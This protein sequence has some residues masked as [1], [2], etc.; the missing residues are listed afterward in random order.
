[1][2]FHSYP[3]HTITS[4]IVNS[5]NPP[6]GFAGGIVVPITTT[7]LQAY[8]PPFYSENAGADK[9]F[10]RTMFTVKPNQIPSTQTNFPV[11]IETT[12]GI[13]EVLQ[14]LGQDIRVVI[15][16]TTLLNYEIE[17]WNST[18]RELVIWFDPLTTQQNTLVELYTGNATV[19]DAQNK[20]GVYKSSFKALYHMNDISVSG[21][22]DI[23]DS[24]SNIASG[25]SVTGNYSSVNGKIGKAIQKLA[26]AN[27]F[28]RLPFGSIL[29]GNLT[30]FTL[31]SLIN[32]TALNGY[33]SLIPFGNVGDEVLLAIHDAKIA[34]F[35]TWFSPTLTETTDTITTGTFAM[36]HVTVE[37][38]N[39]IKIYINGELKKSAT[40]SGQIILTNTNRR[41]F[42]DGGSEFYSGIFDETYI[43][44]EVFSADWIKTEYN[45]QFNNNLFWEK[46]PV[47]LR[48]LETH[49][50]STS[51]VTTPNTILEVTA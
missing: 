24:T 21:Q 39:K 25:A 49:L 2:V 47:E 41:L 48:Q 27:S 19:A 14:S 34:F 36:L 29:S 23:T 20:N 38:K 7:L 12:L 35:S 28:I 31:K 50:I 22:V 3:Q 11:V 33:N 51:P 5:N 40:V 42:G 18:T 37:D 10:F 17:T 26:I 15:N 45:N 8:Q 44:D 4:V 1:M 6:Q 16:G 43:A 46:H 32:P 9:F 13:G 30:N